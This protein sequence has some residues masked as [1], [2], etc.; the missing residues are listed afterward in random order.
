MDKDDFKLRILDKKHVFLVAENNK[1]LAGF[2][3]ANAKDIDRPL[4]NKY[5]CLV[6]V[7]V[8]PEY[9]KQG[10]ATEL[11]NECIKKLKKIGITHIYGWADAD[12]DAI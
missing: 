1:K 4:K 7:V 9:R 3:C 6:Y 5:A 2:I 8:L 11:Y 10:L 12:T